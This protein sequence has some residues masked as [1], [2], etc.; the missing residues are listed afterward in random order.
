MK[1]PPKLTNTEN[2]VALCFFLFSLSSLAQNSFQS[3]SPNWLP[4]IA[5]PAKQNQ[6][7]RI[8]TTLDTDG[9]GVTDDID[10][11]D[12]N[13]GILDT[14]EGFNTTPNNYSYEFGGG[15]GY[16]EKSG[17]TKSNSPLRRT[18]NGSTSVT[19]GKT[20]ENGQPWAVAAVF[21]SDTGNENTI[22]SQGTNDKQVHM[23]IWEKNGEHK[24]RV[25][26]GKSNN[27]YLRFS[28]TAGTD[29]AGRWIG[30]YVDYN[31]GSTGSK[32]AHVD[33]YKTRLRVKLIDCETGIVTDLPGSWGVDN[34]GYKG[35]IGADNT[36]NFYVGTRYLQGNL[37]QKFEGKINSIAVTTL[38]VSN[39]S[40]QVD[41]P[42]DDEIALMTLDPMKWLNDYKI[43]NSFRAPNGTSNGSSFTQGTTN[44]ANA[45]QIYL[46]GDDENDVNNATLVNQV[47]TNHT[48]TQL[49]GTDMSGVSVVTETPNSKLDTDNDGIPNQL[50]IDSDGDGCYDVT[51]AGFDLNQDGIIDGTFDTDGDLEVDTD[52]K[53]T[54]QLAS[55][56]SWYTTTPLDSD[57]SDVGDHLED[58]VDDDCAPL[59]VTTITD[60][61]DLTKEE[62]D[63]DFNLSLMSNS[64]GAVTYTKVS[65]DASTTVT[66]LGMMGR[67]SIGTA[68]TVV[69]RASI[70][71]TATHTSATKDI[72]LTINAAIDTDG[73]G[74]PDKNRFRR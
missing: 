56:N 43:G 66:M 19:D 55:G 52:G 53:V 12:D 64:T 50:D 25:K 47:N 32:G 13:D 38:N 68:G 30:V 62:G 51:E 33:R 10:L 46:F 74:V 58:S 14:D 28:S 17:N 37:K 60:F 69:I 24:I 26:I 16:F 35:N 21:N 9:D 31:G 44:S 40:N 67:V 70:A 63:A 48:D 54:G 59:T 34:K 18:I 57:N 29:Y 11:D 15:G 36:G 22:W 7:F 42:S 71:A 72:T 6:Q 5:L 23:R 41:L 27:Q 65:G 4:N 49:V 45:T 1:I 3:G 73:D 20:A 8:T 61:N 2:I 39:S